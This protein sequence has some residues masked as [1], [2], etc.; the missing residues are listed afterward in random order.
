MQIRDFELDIPIASSNSSVLSQLSGAITSQ[1]G[2][3]SVPIR[4]LV[5]ATTATAYRCEIAVIATGR[6]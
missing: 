3:A 4:F 5:S 1:L 2:Q 6:W